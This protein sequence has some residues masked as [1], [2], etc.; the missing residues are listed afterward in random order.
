MSPLSQLSEEDRA[1]VQEIIDN[2][3]QRV[4]QKAILG[5]LQG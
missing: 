4:T 3:E 5:G 1:R 2:T